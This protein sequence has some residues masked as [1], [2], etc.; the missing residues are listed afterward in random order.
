MLARPSGRLTV[1]DLNN[2]L[3]NCAESL[4]FP[5]ETEPVHRGTKFKQPAPQRDMWEDERRFPWLLVLYVG[6]VLIGAFLPHLIARA[7]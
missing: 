3:P 2:A 1:R 6:A 4:P 5:L 7:A